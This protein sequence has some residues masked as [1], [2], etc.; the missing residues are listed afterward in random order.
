[1]FDFIRTTVELIAIPLAAIL[2]PAV[3]TWARDLS[4]PA[5]RMRRLDEQCKVVSF[6]EN[7]TKAVSSTALPEEHSN[8]L[9]EYS[10]AALTQDARRE[11]L[12]AGVLAKRLYRPSVDPALIKYRLTFEQ[13]Q[14]YRSQLSPYRRA[15]LLYRAPNPLAAMWKAVFHFLIFTAIAE[16]IVL[17]LA[18]SKWPSLNPSP[19]A[20][21]SA[22]E[23]AHH[24]VALFGLLIWLI[25]LMCAALGVILWARRRA[26]WYENDRRCFVFGD[27]RGGG[28]AY[29]L[30]EYT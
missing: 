14:A 6:W 9:D 27:D 18:W 28:R 21:L 24:S 23:K 22:L 30:D 11:L 5:R 7:W 26:I 15:L 8:V 4:S 20:W 25:L 13:F 3:L 10:L 16:P 29:Q 19:P 1:M 12:R 17:V 2:V